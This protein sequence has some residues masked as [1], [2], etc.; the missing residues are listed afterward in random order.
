MRAP[1][2]FRSDSTSLTA[3]VAQVSGIRVGPWLGAIA[4]LVVGAGAWAMLRGTDLG[5]LL[6]ASALSLL[7]SFLLGT[8]AFANYYVLAA[9]LL[10]CAALALAR[11]DGASR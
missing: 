9:A 10:L 5:G 4:Q 3:L 7:A 11:R 2:A 1:S 8:Q 6:L